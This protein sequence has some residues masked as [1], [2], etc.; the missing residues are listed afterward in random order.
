MRDIAREEEGL[1][2]E[3]D[4]QRRCGARTELSE[5][6]LYNWLELFDRGHGA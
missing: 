6:R 3:L 5:L 2:P 1:G 4:Y